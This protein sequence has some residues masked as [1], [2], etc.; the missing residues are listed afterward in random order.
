M[1]FNYVLSISF[2]VIGR[3][4]KGQMK[5]EITN[6]TYLGG[7]I[8]DT[9]LACVCEQHKRDHPTHHAGCEDANTQTKSRLRYINKVLKCVT[10]CGLAVNIWMLSYITWCKMCRLLMTFLDS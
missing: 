5:I 9:A 6:I 7:A 4:N 2:I 1:S 10:H 3:P 8:S